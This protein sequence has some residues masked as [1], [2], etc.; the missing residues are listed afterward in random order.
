MQVLPLLRRAATTEAAMWRSMYLWARRKPVTPAPGDQAFSYLGVVTPILGVFIGLSV[1]E[2]PILDLIIR[3]VVPWAPARWIMLAISVWGLLWMIGLFASLKINPHIVGP[4]GIRVRMGA[5]HD[6]TVPWTDVATVSKAYRTLP[7]SKS[8]QVEPD[9]DRTVLNLPTGSQTAVDIRLRHPV[10]YPLPKGP[11][12][13]ADELRIYVDD[14]D[15]FVRACRQATGAEHA[16]M[17]HAQE[18]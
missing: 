18:G 4:A 8:V 13:P 9:G 2:I 17:R 6:L 3:K 11:S 10:S 14:P 7:S 15:G 5:A 1:V 12:E 16:T